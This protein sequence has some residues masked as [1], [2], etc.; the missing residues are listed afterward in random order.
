MKMATVLGGLLGLSL[1][2]G[3]AIVPLE[4]CGG[5]YGPGYY[6]RGYYSGG[7]YGGHG[8]GRP[9]YYDR[10]HYS[11]GYYPGGRGYWR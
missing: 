6:G 10:G 11:R 3:C 9:G 5:Y 1:L 8:Y 7:Y 2:A 4:P